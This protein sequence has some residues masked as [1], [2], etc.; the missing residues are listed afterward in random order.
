MQA[1]RVLAEKGQFTLSDLDVEQ[2][3]L[4]TTHRRVFDANDNTLKLAADMPLTAHQIAMAARTEVMRKN[5]PLKEAWMKNAKEEWESYKRR[6]KALDED[7]GERELRLAL[8]ADKAQARRDAAK[9]A[10][11]A[12]K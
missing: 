2:K 10:A 4:Y 6:K 3:K 8:A 9:A 5:K 12:S 7:E 11:Q 1:Y